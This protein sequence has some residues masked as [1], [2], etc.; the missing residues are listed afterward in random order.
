MCLGAAIQI[1][2]TCTKIY[3]QTDGQMHPSIPSGLKEFPVGECLFI[4]VIGNFRF[5]HSIYLMF[6]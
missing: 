1:I 4:Y 2:F 5:I 3:S 6:I